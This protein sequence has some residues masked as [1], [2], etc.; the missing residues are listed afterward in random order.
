MICLIDNLR[1][2]HIPRVFAERYGHLLATDTREALLMGPG[3]EEYWDAWYTASMETA[4]PDGERILVNESGDVMKAS[5]AE[6][7][8]YYV[9]ADS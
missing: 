7:V 4:F 5:N 9:E 2:Q 3:H 1:G 6:I 8:S